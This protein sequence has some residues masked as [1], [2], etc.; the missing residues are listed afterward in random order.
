MSIVGLGHILSVGR[1]FSDMSIIIATMITIFTIG[2]LVDRLL[3]FK[4]EEKVRS[5]W[6]LSSD[7]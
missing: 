3:L 4:L 1:E 2:L 6:G 5:R 7:R